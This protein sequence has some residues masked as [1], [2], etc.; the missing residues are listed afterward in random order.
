MS[1]HDDSQWKAVD[2]A[3]RLSDGKVTDLGKRTEGF[4][5]TAPILP[6]TFRHMDPATSPHA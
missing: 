6:L 4:P 1:L 2:S 5:G 3:L